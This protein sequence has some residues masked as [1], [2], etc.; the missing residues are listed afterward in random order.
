EGIRSLLDGDLTVTGTSAASAVDGRV[1]VESVSFTP[2]FDLAK[3]IAAPASPVSPTTNSFADNMKLNIAVQSTENLEAVSS[4]VSLEGSANLR[5]V[6][7]ATQPVVVGRADVN[8][9]DIFF[10]KNRYQL[11]RGIINFVNPNRTEPSVNILITTVI[12]QYNLNIA[13]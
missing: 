9:G 2:E 13:L 8:S 7:T 3:F 1:L 6:G 11:E 5:I 10:M 12:K 4:E